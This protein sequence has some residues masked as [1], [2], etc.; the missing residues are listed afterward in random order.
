MNV[1]KVLGKVH[2]GKMIETASQLC[3]DILDRSL[4]ALVPSEGFGIEGYVRLSYATSM[5][6]ITT[7]LDRIEAYLNGEATDVVYDDNTLVG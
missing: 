5:E 6:V 7:G 3:E 4:V 1:K 2:Y